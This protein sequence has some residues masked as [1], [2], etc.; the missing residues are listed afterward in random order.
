MLEELFD[1]IVILSFLKCHG[2]REKSSMTGRKQMFSTS[3]KKPEGRR[4]SMNWLASLQ[5]LSK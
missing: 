3:L 1:A 5:S 2:D 4:L